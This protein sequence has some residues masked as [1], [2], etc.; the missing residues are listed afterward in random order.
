VEEIKSLITGACLLALLSTCSAKS[1]CSRTVNMDSMRCEYD[2][3]ET[4]S[5]RE[6]N[7]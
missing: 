2:I 3:Y 6:H 1:V 7:I 4:V 5:V